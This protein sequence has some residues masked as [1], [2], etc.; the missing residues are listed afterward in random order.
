[1]CNKKSDYK[2]VRLGPKKIDIPSS[3]E[4]RRLGNKNGICK[5]V[6]GGTPKTSVDEYWGGDINWVTPTDITE[7]DSIY[8]NNSER[9]LTEKGLDESSAKLLP[10]NSI[11]LTTRATIGEA[12]INKVPMATNQGFKSLKCKNGTNHLFLYYIIQNE[13]KRLASYGGGSTF[14]EVN[15]KD[16]QNFPILHPPLPEQRRIAEILSTVD[17]AIQKTDEVIEKAERLKKGLMQDLLTKGI[18]HDEFK[19]IYLGP[20]KN[21]IPQEWTKT[22]LGEISEVLD[23]HR[24]PLNSDERDKMKGDIPYYGANGVVDYVDDYLFDEKLLLIAEDG[25]HFEEHKTRPISYIIEGKSWVNNHAHI[26]RIKDGG[27]TA[28]VYYSTVHKN[29][30][31]YVHGSTRMKLNQKELKKIEIPLPPV[32]EQ[33]RITKILSK[34]DNKIQKEK[35]YNKKLHNLKKGLMQD[36]LTGKVRVNNGNWVN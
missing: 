14:D 13:K 18:G 34:I 17:D 23:R 15:K 21:R 16:V 35:F 1:M 26:L 29:I 27:T 31:P 9:T 7:N 30:L 28:W 20:Q 6:T 12:C 33:K 36:L 5:V 8:I 24:V 2:E 11:L 32:H 4:I 10:E 22:R 25:G 3:W 19:E